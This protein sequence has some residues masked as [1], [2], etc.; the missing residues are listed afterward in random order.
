MKRLAGL[1]AIVLLAAIGTCVPFAVS[2]E[3]AGSPKT[4]DFPTYLR[5]SELGALYLTELK[6]LCLEAGDLRA[7]SE[8]A[9][10]MDRNRRFD[11]VLAFADSIGP[12]RPEIDHTAL[13]IKSYSLFGAGRYR[14]AVGILD[15]LAAM[16]PPEDRLVESVLLRAECQL[17]L[18]LTKEALLNLVAIEPHVK[19]GLR[20]DYL[21]WR[22]KAEE[23]GGDASVAV[24]L[25]GEVWKAGSP[26][27]GL[28][29]VR[30]N[31]RDGNLA[32][33]LGMT[34]EMS[35]R[36]VALPQQDGC[37]LA[38]RFGD[39]LPSLWHALVKSL[40][41]DTTFVPGTCPGTIGSIVRLAE[42]GEDM[43]P[44][45]DAL[46]GRNL[47]L[48]ARQDLKYARALGDPAP[49]SHGDSLA[50]LVKAVADPGLK[51][52][53]LG[54]CLTLAPQ[55]LEEIVKDLGT[56][57]R[58]L[59]AQLAPDERVALTRVLIDFG[60]KDL[61][62]AELKTMVEGLKVG[63]DDQALADVAVL[64]ESAGDWEKAQAI[65]EMVSQ[66]PLPSAA[67][68]R[69]ERQAFL[70]KNLAQPDIDI[71]KE[72]EKIAKKGASDLELGDLFMEKLRDY[73]RAEVYYRKVAGATPPGSDLDRVNLKLAR[74]LALE[75]LKN[76]GDIQSGDARRVEALSILRS[77]AASKAVKPDEVTAAV[78]LSTDWLEH[79][80]PAAAEIALGLS[81]RRDLA[82]ASLYSVAGLLYQLFL[83]GDAGVY[84][85][86]AMSLDRIVTEFGS[87]KQAPL[88]AIALARLKFLAGDYGGAR[89]AYVWCAEKSHDPVIVMLANVG[90]G[91]CYV[92]SGGVA[93]GLDYLRRGA[94]SPQ[95]CYE[96][97][98]CYDVVGQP[99]SSIAYY[100]AAL[101][102]LAPA[103]LMDRARLRLSLR[104]TERDGVE[105]ALA[106]VDSP[107]PQARQRLGDSKRTV[108]AYA[109]GVSGY[110]RLA[111]SIL[112]KIAA[113]PSSAACEAS[114]VGSRLVWKDDPEAAVALLES[115]RPD[116]D[117]IFDTYTLLR[118]RGRYACSSGRPGQ[119][120]E[121]RQEFRR[122]FPLD[123]E[124]HDE[125]GLARVL[126]LLGETPDSTS[127]AP[128]DSLLASA[129]QNPLVAEVL[130]RRG[131][132]LLVR[133]DY[134]RAEQAFR[135][136]VDDFPASEFYRDACFK[137]GSAYYL[138]QK[139]DFSALYFGLAALSDKPSLVRD[140]LFNQ[141]LALEEIGGSGQAA[142]AYRELALR[143]PFSE[144]FERSLVRCGLCLQN[145]NKPAQAIDVYTG[146][147]QY[148][149][150]AS[151]RAEIQFWIAG[152]YSEMGEPLRAACEFLRTGYL[153][154]KEAQWAGTAAFTAGE[155]CEKAGL[156]DHATTIYRQNVRKFGKTSD[157]GKASEA[158]LAELLGAKQG[159]GPGGK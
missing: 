46:I 146:A 134:P 126:A 152:S 83:K 80:R 5:D 155:E 148:A 130:Y 68:M 144:Q 35:K 67:G 39:V 55:R 63:F 44:Y 76:P 56:G 129:G 70:L 157:W 121:A 92:Y 37:D 42:A 150:K 30:C 29:L 84:D 114:L 77:L 149:E 110:K 87:S 9:R 49:G 156:V 118:E 64:V 19:G 51:A 6:R 79:A 99:D 115:A 28:G 107:L 82:A 54:A 122:R 120:T 4:S 20:P 40:V 74:A 45:C 18:G 36:G 132:G 127:Q 125:M 50:V 94:G 17:S 75:A 62:L 89:E 38:I 7:C 141:G 71:A 8:Y 41:A 140:A 53:C 95:V 48:V 116:P 85:R 15:T 25:Y 103:A 112:E 98:R 97:A 96:L 13:M 138:M 106:A 139:F 159:K 151:T 33:A 69:C 93:R 101:A 73:E 1:L 57:I 78:K 90:I 81:A 123:G 136:I 66:S 27:A 113:G 59:L 61:A 102:R 43:R 133:G 72:V 158:R 32:G 14:H 47:P 34:K 10:Q 86:C 58:P 143:F 108:V 124:S 128:S 11:E 117:D 145:D 52:R 137:L 26:D 88:A 142:E 31:L 12:A 109:L 135:R 65:C 3:R 91:E 154:P 153:Y 60:L 22:A 104:I 2:A 105:A 131:I 147:L 24:K 100:R 16:L 21:M 119:C 111:V 23:M